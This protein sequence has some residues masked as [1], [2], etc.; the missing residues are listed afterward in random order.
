MK[1]CSL[2]VALY[3]SRNR[4]VWLPFNLPHAYICS[5]YILHFSYF[6][7]SCLYLGSFW[8]DFTSIRI[9]EMYNEK[10]VGTSVRIEVGS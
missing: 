3:Q 2:D 7:L 4:E 5:G 9:L 6:P 8:C 10:T 1:P